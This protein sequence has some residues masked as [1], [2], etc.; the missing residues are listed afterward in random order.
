MRHLTFIMR[1]PRPEERSSIELPF[2]APREPS[3]QDLQCE[4]LGAGLYLD[5]QDDADE[6]SFGSDPFDILMHKQETTQ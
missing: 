4:A 2:R 5:D 3:H 6:P 1:P